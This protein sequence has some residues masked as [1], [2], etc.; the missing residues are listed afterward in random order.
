MKSQD[1]KHLAY[2]NYFVPEEDLKYLPPYLRDVPET[3]EEVE[4]QTTGVW[5]VWLHGSF[6]RVG[7][8]RFTVPLS[9]DDS[10]PRAVFQH[11]FDGLGM[12]HKFRMSD[13]R[14]HYS[15][16]Y[17][18]EGVVRNAE[19]NGYVSSPMFG[20]NANTPLKHAQ[21]PCSALLGA[22]Q[23]LYVP[24]HYVGPDEVNLNVVPRRGMHLPVDTN[25]HSRGEAHPNP[26]VLVHTDFN[27]LQICDAKTLQPKRLLTYAQIDSQL[28]GFGICA[29][30]PKD[31]KR[32]L[33]FNYIISP[34]GQVLSIFA[35]NIRSNPASLV[36]KTALPF[37]IRNPIHMDVSDT[38]KPIMEMLE[39]EA[40]TPTLFF[41]LDKSS[42]A[43]IATYQLNDGFMFFHSVNAFDYKDPRT[44][45]TNIHVDLCS[46]QDDYIPYREYNISNILDP[47]RPYQ[48]GVLTRYELAS[49]N[50][51]NVVVTRR[52]TV[53][54]AIPGM[55]SE[56]PR[57]AKS[58]SMDPNYRYVYCV[59]GNGGASPGTT[60]PIG[61]LGNGLKVVQAAF[62]GSLGKSDWKTGTYKRWQ[63]DN[64][65][66]CPCEP[67]F[68]QRPGATDE[69]DGLVLTIVINR[70]GTSS[71]LVA[72]DGK[73]FTEVARANLPQVYALGPHGSFIEGP[74][75]V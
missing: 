59:A 15:S 70:E 25:P 28:A 18:A 19:K 20:L 1:N 50:T 3:P 52:A 34:D 61:R 58:A 6:L 42:G 41:V 4:C 66:S 44:G 32:G 75:G 5:P 10:K 27:M 49:V 57:I 24:T 73:S 46:Y 64:G 71:V 21:D 68:I 12:L 43:H 9:E 37:F 16:R 54:A 56:L 55:A 31:R 38:T 47:A 14:V 63:P 2:N 40:N 53:A 22:Q 45:Q 7:A 72:L 29:H 65:E 74:F 69:D 23:S 30:P 51:A 60:V 48:D 36:W 62:F 67:V 35:L 33:V 11:F 39:V 8:G 17:T 13:G 26:E